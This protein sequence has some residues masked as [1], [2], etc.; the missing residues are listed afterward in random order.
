MSVKS[1]N[2]ITPQILLIGGLEVQVV[3]TNITI[4]HRYHLPLTKEKK[5]LTNSDE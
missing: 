1:Y 3:Q 5:P 4:I 2:V